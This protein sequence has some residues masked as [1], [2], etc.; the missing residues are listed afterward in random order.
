MA[1]SRVG[2]DRDMHPEERAALQR[3]RRSASVGIAVIAIAAACVV[4]ALALFLG[5]F[6]PEVG[7]HLLGQSEKHRAT[8]TDIDRVEVCTRSSRHT[9]TFE[10]TEDGARTSGSVSRCGDPWEV[11]DPVEIWATDGEP[12]TQSPLAMGLVTGGVLLAL[13]ALGGFTVR[14]LARQRRILAAA[15]AG[16]WQ[17]ITRPTT[18]QPGTADFRVHGAPVPVR[19]DRVGR[20]R[21][22]HTHLVRG[23]RPDQAPGTLF[24]DSVKRGKPRRL[25]LWT[26]ADGTR[27]WRWH[28]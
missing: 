19:P 3:A 11:G 22:I 14:A 15:L 4:A 9:F 13:A 24:L 5:V 18:G 21:A 17:P 1:G 8:V 28:G 26:G 10:W 2:Q 12:Q 20:G 6:K 7:Q 16:T 23:G 27:L 25:A